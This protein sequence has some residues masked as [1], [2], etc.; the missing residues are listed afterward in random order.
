MIGNLFNFY[1]NGQGDDKRK[2][3]SLLIYSF[4]GIVIG[5]ILARTIS[6]QLSRMSLPGFLTLIS[7]F[8]VCVHYILRKNKKAALHTAYLTPISIYFFFI[9]SDYALIPETTSYYYTCYLLGLIYLFYMIYAPKVKYLL[10]YGAL[11]VVTI[12]GHVLL[13]GYASELLSIT[14]GDF[15]DRMNPVFAFICY[16]SILVF[17]YWFYSRTLEQRDETIQQLNR[18]IDINFRESKQGI[19]VLNIVRDEHNEVSGL[20][21]GRANKVFQDS[22]SIVKRNLEGIDAEAVLSDVFREGFDWHN[23]YLQKG[24]NSEPIYFPHID[25]WFEIQNVFIDNDQIVSY[26]SDLTEQ[27]NDLQ[28]LAESEKRYKALLEAVPDMYFVMDKDGVYVDYVAKEQA[29]LNIN[30]EDIIG[31]SIFEVGFSQKMTRTIYQSIQNVIKFNTIESIEYAFETPHGTMLFEMRMVKLNDHSVISLS[32]DITK[33]KLAEQKMEEAKEKAENAD[34]LKSAFL[35]NLSHEVRTPMN[36]IIGFARM[37][38]SPDF[39]QEDRSRFVSIIV[40]NGELL[41]KMITDMISLSKIEANQIDVDK[42]L[43]KV[44]QLLTELYRT[45]THQKNQDLEKKKN[46]KLTIDSENQNQNFSIYTDGA[47][48]REILSHLIDNAIKFT[49]RG[50]VKFGYRMTDEQHIEFYVEDT[51]IGIPM[52]AHEQVFARF[53]QLDNDKSREYGGTGLGLSIAQHY[54]K[55]LGARIS[56]QSEIN[57]GTRF[58]FAI[59][60]TQ[61]DNHLKIV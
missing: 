5:L 15:G 17:L 60:I 16:S 54:A 11:G 32:R 56:F 31:N 4:L 47:L 41:L 29:A 45:Y 52:D 26:F 27:K 34:R 20:K 25:K 30:P 49:E 13:T 24:K 39:D 18:K 46:L 12:V 50:E 23:F 3:V 10:V 55:Q 42:S 59:K 37:L 28:N 8:L 1:D 19:L 61:A 40:Q 22:F 48:L 44:N 51:G 38:E 57:K 35:A 21:I 9:S 36:A 33:R 43:F 6:S 53:H 58:Y 14:W 2:S 7:L